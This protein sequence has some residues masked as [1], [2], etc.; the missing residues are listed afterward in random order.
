MSDGARPEHGVTHSMVFLQP[1]K[2]DIGW[3]LMSEAR[4]RETYIFVL[5]HYSVMSGG[6]IPQISN[7]VEAFDSATM[8]AVVKTI[9]ATGCTSGL[10]E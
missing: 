1:A 9:V 8:T 2:S 4:H 3:G 6:R 5:S 7:S 10:V